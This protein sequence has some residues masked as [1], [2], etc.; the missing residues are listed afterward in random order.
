[1]VH[2]LD[3]RDP[4]DFFDNEAVRRVRSAINVHNKTLTVLKDS[5]I[6]N[7]QSKYNEINTKKP[8]KNP[9]PTNIY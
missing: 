9:I 6:N 3:G 7:K 2:G 5:P 4:K 1:M 8:P